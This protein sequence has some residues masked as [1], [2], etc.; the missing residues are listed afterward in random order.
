MKRFF[1]RILQD[2]MKK[3][4][5]WNIRNLVDESFV[6]SAQQTSVLYCRLTDL[7]SH[8]LFL[9]RTQRRTLLQGLWEWWGE[10]CQAHDFL[11]PQFFGHFVIGVWWS[12]HVFFFWLQLLVI[13]GLFWNLEFDI[14]SIHYTEVH[15]ATFLSGGFTTMAVINPPERKL[16]KCTSVDCLTTVRLCA[17]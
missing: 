11:F 8:I 6:P 2:F 10:K 4:N 17:S 13:Q 3:N 5:T 16:A 12:V 15:F 14:N 9:G 1:Q 7:K